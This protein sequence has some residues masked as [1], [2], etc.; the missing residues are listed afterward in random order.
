MA[1]QKSDQLNNF[2]V[3][4]RV[5]AAGKESEIHI[6]PLGGRVVISPNTEYNVLI[7]ALD[8]GKPADFPATGD[9][10]PLILKSDENGCV[11]FKHT[12]KSE[13]EYLIRFL[14]EDGKT[15]IQFP[16]YCVAQDLAGRY[17]YMGDLHMHTTGSDGRQDPEVVCA[18][19]R[20]YGYDF[21]VISDHERYYPSLRAIS[22]YKDVPVNLNIIH[23]EEVH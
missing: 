16:V 17:P 23:G 2:D 21:T 19:Y 9:F 11:T 15:L 22:A 18:N 1:H 20:K 10:C 6:R 14:K 3:Y 4:P 8:G 5:F 7:C 12:F 13:Q